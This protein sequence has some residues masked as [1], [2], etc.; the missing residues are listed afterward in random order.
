MV[1]ESNLQITDNPWALMPMPNDYR[2][3]ATRMD[4]L[5]LRTMAYDIATY[6]GIPQDMFL[7]L[8]RH[9]SSWNPLN[10]NSKSSATGLGQIIDG[11]ARGLGL[12]VT[13]DEMDERW[14]PGLNMDA[15]ARYLIQL[16]KQYGSWQ[17]AL[18]FYGER[19]QKYIDSVRAA[20]DAEINDPFPQPETFTGLLKAGGKAGVSKFIDTW[21]NI[22]Y[23]ANIL[24]QLG[25]KGV[26]KPPWEMDEIMAAMPE[27]GLLYSRSFEGI[28][29]EM[30]RMARA[31]APEPYERPYTLLGKLTYAMGQAPA[32]IARYLPFMAIGGPI[33]GFAMADTL[34]A[35]DKGITPMIE[36]AVGGLAMGTAFKALE[37]MKYM[38]KLSGLGLMGAL[39]AALQGGD[40][41]DIEASAITMIG[42]GALSGAGSLTAKQALKASP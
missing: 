33:F 5:T 37:P 21:A 39:Q 1:M 4:K 29:D 6:Y 24:W 14:H 16:K 35:V 38:S 26:G 9:E 11:T 7:G 15:A 36:A 34:E 42:L 31:W 30:K 27:A 17:K 28:T 8:M 19:S 23:I 22:P 18:W 25:G 12:N 32:E 2:S 20:A 41:S 10:K 3:L 13:N 40:A